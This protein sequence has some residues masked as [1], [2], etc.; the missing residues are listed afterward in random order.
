M[1][2]RTTSF[3][4]L[5]LLVPA[6]LVAQQG[7]GAYN[8]M[9]SLKEPHQGGSSNMHVLSH[10]PLGSWS[11]VM[12]IEM[13]QELS[14]PYVYVARADWDRGDKNLGP[15]QTGGEV[16]AQAI[17]SKGVDIISIKDPLHAK[18]IYEWRIENQ[19]LH[20][21]TGG[22]DNEYFKLKGRYY[23][24]QSTQFIGS[25]PDQD[26]GAVVLDV[27]GLPDTSKVK[28]AGRLKWAEGPG[29]FHDLFPYK[30]SDGRVIV[31]TTATNGGANIYDMEKFLSGDAKQGLVGRMPGY[32]TAGTAREGGYHDFYVAYDPEKRMDLFY[33]S[34]AGGIHVYDITK[35]DAP[36]LLYSITGVAGMTGGHTGTPDPT[37]RYVIAET[38]Y[39]FAPLRLFDLKPARDG[40]TKVVS[41]PIGAWTGSWNGNAHNH[42]VRWPYVFVSGYMDGLQVFN[43][44]DPTNPYT[45]GY[46]Y[47]CDCL[48]PGGAMGTG[49]NGG[50]DGLFGV[51][52]RNA[53]GLIVGSDRR[54]GF[55]L[56]KMDGFDGWNGHQW[57]LPNISS[58]QDWDNGPEGAPK[59]VS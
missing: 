19:E 32:Q 43:M 9:R 8:P 28:E 6:T 7:A 35:L 48:L 58:V 15:P 34:G 24:M 14:R 20:S 5:L 56:L 22:M 37:G 3:A 44:M 31:F 30:H 45:V 18:V 2:R 51:D 47:T 57:G 16:S 4:T 39:Q 50:M 53:D 52:V 21:Q 49:Q 36:V 55:W 1:N 59:K 26:M 13:E 17:R 33:G 41:R 54:S 10:V 40:T 38:E 25:G 23:D 29:G 42:E 27:T 46:Y 11:H 12:D